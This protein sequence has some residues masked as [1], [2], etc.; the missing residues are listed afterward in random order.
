MPGF[1]K[2]FTL[3]FV[4]AFAVAGGA[5]SAAGRDGPMSARAEAAPGG[6][7]S[8]PEPALTSPIP[9]AGGDRAQLMGSVCRSGFYYCW[10][11][12]PLPVGSSC[13]CNVGFWGFV[14]MQ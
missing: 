5:A 7:M 2:T 13:Y 14:S 11:P 1:A 10:L 4:L 6:P 12:F 8:R 9:S 3:A